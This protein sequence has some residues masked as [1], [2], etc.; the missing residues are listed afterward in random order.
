[1]GLVLMTCAILRLTSDVSCV[2]NSRSHSRSKDKS[3]IQLLLIIVEDSCTISLGLLGDLSSNLLPP[4]NHTKSLESSN[5]QYFRGRLS[6]TIEP[7]TFQDDSN[8]LRTRKTSEYGLVL[9]RLKAIVVIRLTRQTYAKPS[10][11]TIMT[12][13]AHLPGWL[14]QTCHRQSSTA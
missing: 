6:I 3:S 7:S 1:M 8:M 10:R 4:T 5:A 11:H 2:F 13:A 14:I 9:K 12:V